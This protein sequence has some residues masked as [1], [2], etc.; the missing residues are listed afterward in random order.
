VGVFLPT[1]A[2]LAERLSRE[3]PDSLIMSRYVRCRRPSGCGRGH[4]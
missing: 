1:K 3:V 2:Y 4:R